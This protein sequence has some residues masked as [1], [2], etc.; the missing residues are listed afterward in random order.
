MTAERRIPVTQP[1]MPPLDEYVPLLSAIWDSKML[2]NGGAFHEELERELRDRL[3]VDHL[4]LFTNGTIA[5]VTALQALEIK[6]EVITTPYSFAAT[7]HSLWWNGIKPIFVDIDSNTCNLDPAR[8]EAAIT[9]RTSAILAVHCYGNPCDV[10]A[11]QRVADVRGLRVI[12][13]AAHAFDVKYRGSTILNYGDLAVLSFHATKVFTT[14]EGGAVISHAPAMKKRVDQLKN[15]GFVDETTIVAPGINGK[16]SEVQA[17]FGLLQLRY[18]DRAVIARGHLDARYRTEL[19]AV[20]GVVPLP[21]NPLATPNFGY[22]PILVDDRYPLSRDELYD[23]LKRHGILSRRYFY[24]LLSNL[25][26]YEGIP[27]AAVS[28]LPIANEVAGKVLCLPLY[29]DL[30]TEDQDRIIDIVRGR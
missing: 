13:D 9:P 7:V 10:D 1:F 29:P 26:M 17:A 28:N 3:G 16:M 15:F 14:F 23:A 25:P 18:I 19:E 4:S 11:I 30:T 8:I 21:L 27:S 12:Y 20:P 24:P 22:F 5:L 2:T 6:G